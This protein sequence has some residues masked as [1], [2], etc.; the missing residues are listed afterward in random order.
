MEA[1]RF[2]QQFVLNKSARS[3]LFY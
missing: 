2:V 3:R 1:K